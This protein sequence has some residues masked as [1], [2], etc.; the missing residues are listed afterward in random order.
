MGIHF[1]K[2][3]VC[4]SDLSWP[5]HHTHMI[6][7]AGSRYISWEA[8]P[9]VKL[10]PGP[11]NLCWF[12][13]EFTSV[14]LLWS[15]RVHIWLWRTLCLW[16]FLIL[17]QQAISQRLPLYSLEYLYW[18]NTC[19]VYMYNAHFRCVLLTVYIRNSPLTPDSH[20]SCSPSP[21]PYPQGRCWECV[22]DWRPIQRK[23]Y[24]S[25]SPR[26]ALAG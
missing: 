8:K 14:L 21:P 13:C 22:E 19:V 2:F 23:I 15:C 25:A 9:T 6:I 10:C 11:Q 1:S 18:L 17:E 4:S 24:T 20:C 7:T 16:R 5:V 26:H 12:N 3:K